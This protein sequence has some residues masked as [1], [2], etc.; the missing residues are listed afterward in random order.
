MGKTT[1]ESIFPP[2]PLPSSRLGVKAE[3]PPPHTAPCTL[4]PRAP[5]PG[6][7][8][9]GPRGVLTGAAVQ[10]AGLGDVSFAQP[11]ALADGW[12]DP[13]HIIFGQDGVEEN[14]P[15]E[16]EQGEA[17]LEKQRAAKKQPGGGLKGCKK[18]GVSQRGRAGCGPVPVPRDPELPKGWDG[19]QGEMRGCRGG[20]EG[21][22]GVG[23]SPNFLGQ[24]P[25]TWS[26]TWRRC[27]WRS[28]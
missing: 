11:R 1:P 14:T 10:L 28:A 9:P 4:T 12:P 18:E 24:G 8:P 21:L 15:G 13:V 5:H 25:K 3:P 19:A 22:A 26:R 20:S 17:E 6:E 7:A 16:R 2:A 27:S 23:G